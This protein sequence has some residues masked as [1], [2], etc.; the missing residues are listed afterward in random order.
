MIKFEEL[1]A[2]H[3]AAQNA[4]KPIKEKLEIARK[5]HD[6]DAK[7]AV[8]PFTDMLESYLDQKLRDKK[9]IPIQVGAKLTFKNKEYTVLERGLQFCFGQMFDNSRCRIA[10]IRPDGTISKNER[11]AYSSDLKEYEITG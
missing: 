5:Q 11:S 8:Q 6:E 1:E 2:A 9:D 3:I 10:L 4:V 7:I